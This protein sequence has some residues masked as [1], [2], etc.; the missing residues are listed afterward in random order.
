MIGTRLAVTAVFGAVVLAAAGCGGGGGDAATTSTT[1]TQPST[2]TTTT[3]AG[4]TLDATVG[5]GFTISLTGPDG[6]AVTTVK[7]G[8]YTINVDD[9]SDVHNFHL[10]GAGVDKSTDISF[11]GT[12]SWTVTL[13][14]GTYTFQCDPHASSMHGSF[15]VSG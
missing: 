13:Q 6:K 1:A 3:A 11:Q 14:D 10:S 8:T 2:T 9:K 12:E 15:T 4:T 5:P 7:A